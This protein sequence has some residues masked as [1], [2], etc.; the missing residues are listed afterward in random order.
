MTGKLSQST[1]AESLKG[2]RFEVADNN[3]MGRAFRHWYDKPGMHKAMEKL[4]ALCDEHGISTE[5]ASLRW[6]MFHSSLKEGD[7][8][9]V[10]ASK[11]SQIEGCGKMI[12][13]G[14]LPE[15]LVTRM[16]ALWDGCKSDAAA[17]V[18]Y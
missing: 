4:K 1:D 5:E 16:N 17:I 7:G 6:I 14:Y 2:T 3:P 15:D 12:T 10:G 18:Q 13:F 11:P 8:V 9:I